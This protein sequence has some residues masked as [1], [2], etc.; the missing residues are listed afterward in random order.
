MN[1]MNDNQSSEIIGTVASKYRYPLVFSY[2]GKWQLLIQS[3][4]EAAIILRGNEPTQSEIVECLANTH[5][6]ASVIPWIEVCIKLAR[7]EPL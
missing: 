5:F 4:P 6:P 1:Q 7:R 2:Q 3:K